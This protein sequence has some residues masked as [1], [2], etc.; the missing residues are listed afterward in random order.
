MTST[1]ILL[2]LEIF[3]QNFY[4]MELLNF[5]LV[6]VFLV[7]GLSLFILE[8]E[9]VDP[10]LVTET[11]IVEESPNSNSKSPDDKEFRIAWMAPK[12]EFHNFSAD[13]SVGALKLGLL[14]IDRDQ[15]LHGRTVR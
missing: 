4:K 11:K 8:S 10:H 5:R 2:L 12:E 1:N 9:T 14:Q 7:F 13:T 3:V 6:S 15:Y